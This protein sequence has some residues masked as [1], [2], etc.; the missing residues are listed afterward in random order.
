[1][2]LMPS[3]WFTSSVMWI[4]L[5]C[6]FLSS[7]KLKNQS[8]C[9][10]SLTFLISIL[11]VL[12]VLQQSL[13]SL[14]YFL[15]DFH[16]C[17]IVTFPNPD[18]SF[19]FLLSSCYYFHELLYLFSVLLFYRNKCFIEDFCFVVF[20]FWS[21][22]FEFVDL[23]LLFHFFACSCPLSVSCICVQIVRWSVVDY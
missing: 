8:F 13:F 1:M 15:F 10:I 3:F 19:Y 17:N 16:F 9:F 14:C 2:C 5:S 4:C 6:N 21:A 12:I 20:L 7:F 23:V 22:V 11:S 18:S